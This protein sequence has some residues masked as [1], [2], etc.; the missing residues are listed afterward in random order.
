MRS[1][2]LLL[3]AFLAIL[4]DGGCGSK[5]EASEAAKDEPAPKLLEIGGKEG[6]SMDPKSVKLAGITV[7]KAGSDGL[8]AS[9]QRTGEVEATD[10]GTV[11][12]TSRLPGKITEALVNVGDRV[13][14]GQVI[15]SVDSVDLATAEATYQTAVSHVG[16]AKHQLE[17]QKRLA[18]YGALSEQAVED[19]RKA[20]VGADAAVGGD[21]AQIKVDR[22]A[23]SSTKDLVDMGEVTRKPLEDA[24]NAYSQAQAAASQAAAT[25]HSTKSTYDRAVILYKGGVFSRQQLEDAETAYNTATAADTQS[26][27]AEQLAKEEL[28]R[29]QLVFN[30]NLN[31][32]ASLQGAQSKVQQDQHTYQNDLVAQQLA[33]T[34]YRRALAIRKSGIPVNQAIQSAQDAYDEAVVAE[35]GA[36][37]T[38]KLYGV[39][40]GDAIGGL[41]MGRVVI[42]ILAPIDG[43]VAARSMVVG[44]NIDTSTVLARVVNLDRVYIDAQVFE[45]DIQ[46]VAAGDSVKVHV[47]AF[48]DRSFVGKVQFVAHEVST[49]TRTVL[50]RTVLKNPGWLLRPGMFASAVI[51]SSKQIHA[52]SVPAD[53]VL[54]ED[55][56]QIVYVQTSPG[57]FQKRAVRAGPPVAGKLPIESGIQVGDEV[58]VGGNV[59]IQKAQEQL[60]NGKSGE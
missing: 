24:Q 50:V 11:Q 40:P 7:V 58:V 25:L 8:T 29:Q 51:G 54:Q 10:S 55:E 37:N 34:Q 13:R 23:L 47:A 28:N 49:D 60:E 18:G 44:Q 26:E 16:L 56:K 1:K 43:I 4:A 45:E 27:T 3:I 52:V 19:A 36:A 5:P 15:A 12:I 39:R 21:E 57:Q 42:P 9:L 38:L 6:V 35:R 32:A 20:A 14:K 48:P 30:K 53:A 41:Q 59:L 46:G 2:P 22:L 33:H 17:Q 31:G